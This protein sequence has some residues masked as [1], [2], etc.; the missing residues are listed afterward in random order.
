MLKWKSWSSFVQSFLVIPFLFHSIRKFFRITETNLSRQKLSYFRRKTV[1]NFP[2]NTISFQRSC[3]IHYSLC[4]HHR[5]RKW[6]SNTSHI[7]CGVDP[8]ISRSMCHRHLRNDQHQRWGA[9]FWRDRSPRYP[10]YPRCPRDRCP[11]CPRLRSSWSQ[12]PTCRAAPM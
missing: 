5:L 8:I 7:R 9:T 6:V 3:S 2:Q 1:P 11:S 10:R 4:P 12:E